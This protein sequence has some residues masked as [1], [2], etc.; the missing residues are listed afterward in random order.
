MNT[1]QPLIVVPVA[2]GGYEAWECPW[3]VWAQRPA[4]ALVFNDKEKLMK[5]L[6]KH[7]EEWKFHAT[8][9]HGGHG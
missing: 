3:P 6:D 7:F 4:E 5:F 1:R 8:G 9:D 2:L